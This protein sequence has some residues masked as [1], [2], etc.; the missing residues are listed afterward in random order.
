MDTSLDYVCAKVRK[1]CVCLFVC[2]INNLLGFVDIV[3]ESHMHMD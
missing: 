2:L 1:V 3:S